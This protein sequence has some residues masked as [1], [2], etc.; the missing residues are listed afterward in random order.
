MLDD[1]RIREAKGKDIGQIADALGVH[2]L[3][4]WP[5]RPGAESVG[6]CPMC[7][8]RDRFS[9]N[10]NKALFNCRKCG[11]AGDVIHLV[12]FVRGCGLP[13]ALDWLCGPKQELSEAERQK[14]R[15]AD[16]ARAKKAAFDEDRARRKAIDAGREVW[17]SGL[18]AEDSAV[19]DYLALRGIT[20]DLLPVLPRVLRFHPD[21]PYL[22]A[23]TGGRGGWRQ[24][25][26]GPAML[27][28][29]QGVDGVGR[30][31][32]RTWFDLGAAE[33]KVAIIDPETGEAQK[34]K[35][36]LGSKKGAVV[37]LH[38]PA[39]P[40]SQLV[41]GEGIETTLTAMVSGAFPDAAFWAGI[42]LGNFAGRK[43]QGKGLKFAG[44]PDLTDDRAFVPPAH[45]RELI[46]IEDG[47]SDPRVTRAALLA[48]ARR[49]M[50]AIP[51]LRAK[52]VPCPR[53]ADLNDVL[54]SAFPVT[55]EGA[56]E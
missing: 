46:L 45:V 17:R 29:M 28:V 11:G 41:M 53:G 52:I 35:K 15:E 36:G 20:R 26:R 34:R 19:R 37:M 55:R 24:I 16:E 10:A 40:W 56:A 5:P 22:V 23:A 31:C 30:G 50:V 7:G 14:R 48:G 6:P 47:D 33:G 21:L 27:A 25:H 38:T 44:L 12:R 1:G 9:I 51:G 43:L 39:G 4:P 2:G 13:E 18:P 49:A 8:G 32:H 3:K 42:D 54:I